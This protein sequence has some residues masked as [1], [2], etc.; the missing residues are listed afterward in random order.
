MMPAPFISVT[1]ITEHKFPKYSCTSGIF[2]M[3]IPGLC[4][5]G[6]TDPRNKAPGYVAFV[7]AESQRLVENQLNKEILS[8][9]ENIYSYHL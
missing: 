4:A 5:G 3:I 6:N 7:R 9:T 1:G 8:G 2:I